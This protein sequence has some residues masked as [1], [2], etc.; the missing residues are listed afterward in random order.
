MEQTTNAEIL[1]AAA[2]SLERNTFEI[3]E[4]LSDQSAFPLVIG[5]EQFFPRESLEDQA[6]LQALDAAREETE[7][8]VAFVS[9]VAAASER[10]LELPS[11]ALS[12]LNV[13]PLIAAFSTQEGEDAEPYND[14]SRNGG[15]S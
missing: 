10:G 4:E 13:Q 12:M 11:G 15:P 5:S 6:T 14:E 8:A 2:R 3:L 7:Q 1:L 9:L